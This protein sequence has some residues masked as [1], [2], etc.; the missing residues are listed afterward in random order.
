V[1]AG[2]ISGNEVTDEHSGQPDEETWVP[3]EFSDAVTSLEATTVR[4]DVH[5]EPIRPP[6]R[7]APWSYAVSTDVRDGTGEEVATGRL[8]LLYNPDGHEAWNGVL[9]LVAYASVDLDPQMAGDPLLPEVGWSWLIGALNDRG[10]AYTAA[11]GTVT[12]TT[13]SR[14]GDIPD[15]AVTTTSLELRCSWTAQDADL[16]LHLLAFSDL[17]CTAAGLPPEGV[18]VL[19]Q[20]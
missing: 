18:T 14:F 2:L 11:G 3:P 17:L 10:A 13:S 19:G 20:R 15:T 6:Q 1:S 8:V 4:S 9:R 7:L 12:Q 5:I 16:G